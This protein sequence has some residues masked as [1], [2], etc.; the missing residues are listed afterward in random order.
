MELLAILIVIGL[1]TILS[2]LFW[3]GFN[4]LVHK[5]LDYFL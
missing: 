5:I 1:I 4:I 3:I 2:I